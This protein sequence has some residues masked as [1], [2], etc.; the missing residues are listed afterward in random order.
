MGTVFR[1]PNWLVPNNA[2]KTNKANY[3]LDFDASSNNYIEISE[4]I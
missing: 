3:S 2:N 1:N 4:N